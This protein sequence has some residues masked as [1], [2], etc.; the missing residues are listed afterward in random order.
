MSQIKLFRLLK[1][2][3]ILYPFP[4]DHVQ[5]D[6]VGCHK[7]WYHLTGHSSCWCSSNIVIT[8]HLVFIIKYNCIVHVKDWLRFCEISKIV[9]FCDINFWRILACGMYHR[10]TWRK[11]FWHFSLLVHFWS[12][13]WTNNVSCKQKNDTQK[14]IICPILTPFRLFLHVI[15]ITNLSCKPFS[16]CCTFLTFPTKFCTD[17]VV[18]ILSRIW[19][20]SYMKN[21]AKDLNDN[22]WSSKDDKMFTQGFLW[23]PCMII[24]E[25]K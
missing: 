8:S 22:L 1:S 25:T 9:S 12:L 10:M 23:Q 3:V 18:I 4:Q 19:Q 5:W 20:S 21:L 14:S 11:N 24:L 15:H 17:K 16:A 2:N 7:S 6:I 13:C